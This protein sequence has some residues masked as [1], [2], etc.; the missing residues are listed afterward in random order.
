[1]DILFTSASKTPLRH[2]IVLRRKFLFVLQEINCWEICVLLLLLREALIV[3]LRPSW[4]PLYWLLGPSV[5]ANVD[6]SSATDVPKYHLCSVPSYYSE[7]LV[8]QSYRSNCQRNTGVNWSANWHFQMR[9]DLLAH[10]I[11]K[12]HLSIEEQ[13]YRWY[14]GKSVL[15]HF[16]HEMWSGK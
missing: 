11:L 8:C 1:M 7:Q 5:S 16:G 13:K 4:V 9:K 15:W 14:I 12:P 10:I 6:C 2:C 3:W